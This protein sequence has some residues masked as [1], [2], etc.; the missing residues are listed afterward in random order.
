MK[1]RLCF[2]AVVSLATLFFATPLAAQFAGEWRGYFQEQWLCDD[3]ANDFV[4]PGVITMR[5]TQDSAGAVSGAATFITSVDE[6]SVIPPQTNRGIAI[7]GNVSGTTLTGHF[8]DMEDEHEF[9]ATLTAGPTLKW[10]LTKPAPS[11]Y[12]LNTTLVRPAQRATIVRFNATPPSIALGGSTRLAWITSNATTVSITEVAGPAASGVAMATP[13]VAGA[14]TYTLTATG[15]NGVAVTRT[16]TIN[17][18]P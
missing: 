5:L 14:R 3:G 9:E 2:A 1:S 11:N 8:F 6:C 16:L 15:Q 4:A 12:T 13:A 17:V 18:T 10:I 7:T